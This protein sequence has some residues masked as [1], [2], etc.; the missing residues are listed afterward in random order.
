MQKPELL[1]ALDDIKKLYKMSDLEAFQYADPILAACGWMTVPEFRKAAEMVLKSAGHSRPKPSEFIAAHRQAGGSKEK[2]RGSCGDCDG[3]GLITGYRRHREHNT[4]IVTAASC[5]TCVK[6][7]KPNPDLVDWDPI[8]E[9]DYY[10]ALGGSRFEAWKF[11]QALGQQFRA[12][13]I[14][15]E[16]AL[17]MGFAEGRRLRSSDNSTLADHYKAAQIDLDIHREPKPESADSSLIS[18]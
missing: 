12:K 4:V 3:T 17:A 7:W 15:F 9:R 1:F 8:G 11:G 5:P 14:P 18:E 16:Q 13:A 6:S 2:P 10:E